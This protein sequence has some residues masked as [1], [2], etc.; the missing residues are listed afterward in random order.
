MLW[1]PCVTS[2]PPAECPWCV[3]WRRVWGCAGVFQGLQHQQ[4]GG[5]HTHPSVYLSKP[6]PASPSASKGCRCRQLRYFNSSHIC[7]SPDTPARVSRRDRHPSGPSNPSIQVFRTGAS[8]V[9]GTIVPSGLDHSAT[10]P[11]GALPSLGAQP[12]GSIRTCSTKKSC[13]PAHSSSP[14]AHG[15]P[16]AHGCPARRGLHTTAM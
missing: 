8:C 11:R 10:Q 5:V 7:L 16:P 6:T 9:Y 14:R 3:G 1:A 13:N 2:R 15:H 4:C 12:T